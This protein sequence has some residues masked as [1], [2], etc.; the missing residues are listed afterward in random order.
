MVEDDIRDGNDNGQSNFKIIV[1][2]KAEQ[3]YM[4]NTFK[5]SGNM[6]EIFDAKDPKED[7]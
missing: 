4:V 7:K 2:Q 1:E 6:S 3:D 5:G